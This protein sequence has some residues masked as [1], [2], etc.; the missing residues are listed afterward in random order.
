MA[1]REENLKKINDQLEQLN[2]EELE[3]IAGGTVNELDDLTTAMVSKWPAIATLGKVAAHTPGL[4]RILANE[5]ENILKRD[6]GIEASISLGFLGTGLGSDPN[7]YR[8]LATGRG[9][10]HAEVLDRINN[11][12]KHL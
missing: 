2:D 12:E 5:A 9:L 6:L 10:S 11:A 3:K 7:S 1:T 8:D 4:N